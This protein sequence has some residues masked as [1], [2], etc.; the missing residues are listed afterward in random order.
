M[1]VEISLLYQTATAANAKEFSAFSIDS[2]YLALIG[3]SQGVY[4]GGKFIGANPVAE[5]NTKLDKI[6]SLELA[7]K[8][9]VVKS[10]TWRQTDVS[11]YA[12]GP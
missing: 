4:V 6:R 3:F 9:T 8:A 5:L 2:A 10:A 12:I 7:F 11:S 1:V